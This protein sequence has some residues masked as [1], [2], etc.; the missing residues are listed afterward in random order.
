LVCATCSLIL[1][2]ALSAANAYQMHRDKVET[3]ADRQ[4]QKCPPSGES[5]RCYARIDSCLRLVCHSAAASTSSLSLVLLTRH[6][7]LQALMGG[8]LGLGTMAGAAQS[9]DELA[10]QLDM[11]AATRVKGGAMH[12]GLFCWIANIVGP[13]RAQEAGHVFCHPN[14]CFRHASC[15]LEGLGRTQNAG[16][17]PEPNHAPCRPRRHRRQR[18]RLGQ[19]RAAHQVL[20]AAFDGLRLQDQVRLRN[21][22]VVFCRA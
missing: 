10:W 2:M 21:R 19:G 17:K 3:V 22:L 12:T 7:R 20:R 4:L 5:C 13:Y 1:A 11:R 9:R 16:H 15:R 8:E 18:W 14:N 6:L